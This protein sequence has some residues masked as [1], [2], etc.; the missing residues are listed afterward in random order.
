MKIYN[1]TVLSQPFLDQSESFLEVMKTTSLYV[2]G[3]SHHFSL[4]IKALKQIYIVEIGCSV[5]CSC[6]GLLYHQL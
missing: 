3:S 1:G 2:R 6:Q 5:Y 4:K